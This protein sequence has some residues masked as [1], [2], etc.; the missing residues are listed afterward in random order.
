MA[1]PS[2]CD[3]AVIGAGLSGLQA[4]LSIKK[5]APSLSIVVLEARERVGGR[6][7]SVNY[8]EGADGLDVGYVLSM[9]SRG[10]HGMQAR[11]LKLC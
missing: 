7:H 3:V 1:L 6:T 5:A 10:H 4:A 9:H 8:G 11:L 2:Q